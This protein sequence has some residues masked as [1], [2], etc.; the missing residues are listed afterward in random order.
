M[1]VQSISTQKNQ[2][3]FGSVNIFKDL[4]P[5]KK[6]GIT[7]FANEDKDLVQFVA[8][9]HLNMDL[10]L[11]FSENA[12]TLTEMLTNLGE[13]ITLPE[14]LAKVRELLGKSVEDV[15]YG[16]GK[17]Y[18]L[19]NRKNYKI[20]K[21]TLAGVQKAIKEATPEYHEKDE[22]CTGFPSTAYLCFKV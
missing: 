20:N 18:K 15:Q 3:S 4:Y 12:E 7:I 1:L 8:P 21:E 6:F 17:I 16:L 9:D 10:K 22:L 11:G 5:S 2:T 13:K 19:T 14:N